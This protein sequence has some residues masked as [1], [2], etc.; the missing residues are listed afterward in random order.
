MLE[1]SKIVMDYNRPLT[2]THCC[3]IYIQATQTLEGG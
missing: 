2:Q 1:G 3:R